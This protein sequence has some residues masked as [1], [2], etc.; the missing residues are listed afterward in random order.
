MADS[1]C[2]N[3]VEHKFKRIEQ[4]FNAKERNAWQANNFS[5]VL[6]YWRTG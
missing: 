5:A 1:L 3:Y 6:T 2:I 4:T